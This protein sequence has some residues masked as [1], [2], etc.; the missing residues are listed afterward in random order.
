MCSQHGECLAIIMCNAKD[1]NA[2]FLMH[3]SR[4]ET[5]EEKACF[6]KF[7]MHKFVDILI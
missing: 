3:A 1:G 7:M 6:S 5:D 4:R 2:L